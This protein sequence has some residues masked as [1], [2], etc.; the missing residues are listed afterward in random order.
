MNVEMTSITILDDI[1]HFALHSLPYLLGTAR[2]QPTMARN[3]RYDLAVL[4]DEMRTFLLMTEVVEINPGRRLSRC[5]LESTTPNER[6]LENRAEENQPQT[7]GELFDAAISAAVDDTKRGPLTSLQLILEMVLIAGAAEISVLLRF[8]FRHRKKMSDITFTAVNGSTNS[9]YSKKLLNVD[10][11]PRHFVLLKPGHYYPKLNVADL[12]SL[13]NWKR[14]CVVGIIK[15]GKDWLLMH[16]CTVLLLM[17]AN[18]G[19][20]VVF[21]GYFTFSELAAINTIAVE[22]SNTKL[23]VTIDV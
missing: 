21:W 12:Q 13:L 6:Q 23:T 22:I 14:I 4:L 11:N 8:K 10:M 7:L 1:N 19:L 15:T 9:T 18:E 3:D 5:H 17:M 2:R 20:L 16:P